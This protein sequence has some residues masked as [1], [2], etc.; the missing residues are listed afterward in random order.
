MI[1]CSQTHCSL[2]DGGL[3][4]R[5]LN[6]HRCHAVS[7]ATSQ[8][9]QWLSSQIVC[10]DTVTSPNAC[11]PG[12]QH[13]LASLTIVFS[14]NCLH[15]GMFML[16]KT[17]HPVSSLCGVRLLISPHTL[18]MQPAVCVHLLGKSSSN[19]SIDGKLSVCLFLSVCLS[20][21]TDVASADASAQ[22]FPAV[23]SEQL[24]KFRNT[25][26]SMLFAEVQN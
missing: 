23:T 14:E 8:T 13:Y 17:S 10:A 7:M 4:G 20:V 2:F 3:T 1:V 18:Q 6:L 15:V 19:L 24:Y 12:D 5:A 11:L 9:K 25:R 21:R 16:V 22:L 26:R